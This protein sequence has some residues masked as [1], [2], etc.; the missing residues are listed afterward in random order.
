MFW[1][2]R[3]KR[4][5]NKKIKIW[6]YLLL[7]YRAIQRGELTGTLPWEDSVPNVSRVLDHF[8]YVVS[9]QSCFVIDSGLGDSI[10]NIV[11]SIFVGYWTTGIPSCLF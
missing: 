3:D 6:N 10:W 8:F 5:D 7:S 9:A 2:K 1:A 4:G 11:Q